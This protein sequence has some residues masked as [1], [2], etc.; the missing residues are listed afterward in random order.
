MKT[1]D[2][3]RVKELDVIYKVKLKDEDDSLYKD[4]YNGKTCNCSWNAV[5][6]CG[7]C[8]YQKYTQWTQLTRDGKSRGIGKKAGQNS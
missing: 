3:Q 2:D 4:N 1:R 8:P 5:V 6:K 7:E